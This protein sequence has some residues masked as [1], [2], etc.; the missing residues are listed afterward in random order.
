MTIF[1]KTFDDAAIDYDHSRP[2]YVKEIYED[3]FRYKPVDPDSHVLEIG[4]GTGKASQPILET[5]CHLTG[6]EPG[7]RL[8]DLARKQYQTYANFTVCNQTFQDFISP[9]ESFDLI[10]SST[11]SNLIREE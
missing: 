6:I 8:A 11:A 9:D 10:Y 1:E 7:E 2:T 3:I 5:R 4:L